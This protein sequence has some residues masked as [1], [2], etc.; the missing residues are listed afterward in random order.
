MIASNVAF[1]GNK[2]IF[3]R[4]KPS[5]DTENTKTRYDIASF[6]IRRR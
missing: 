5:F 6:S 1:M 2:I 3:V 4:M